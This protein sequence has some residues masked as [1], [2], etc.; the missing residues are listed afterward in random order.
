MH[1]GTIFPITVENAKPPER[2]WRYWLGRPLSFVVGAL[3]AAV[4]ASGVGFGYWYFGQRPGEEETAERQA[5]RDAY[6]D[7]RRALV[8]CAARAGGG[9]DELPPAVIRDIVRRATKVHNRAWTLMQDEH[10]EEAVAIFVSAETILRG[11]VP[12]P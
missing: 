4:I 9:S 1:S 7:S 12:L 2:G 8:E 6:Q 3:V 5:A 11:C 10:Y